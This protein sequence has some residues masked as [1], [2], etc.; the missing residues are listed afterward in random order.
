MQIGNTVDSY[1]LTITCLMNFTSVNLQ[2]Q[3]IYG[4]YHLYSLVTKHINEVDI[5]TLN[6]YLY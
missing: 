5:K 3:K 4:S 2:L 6:R 1:K